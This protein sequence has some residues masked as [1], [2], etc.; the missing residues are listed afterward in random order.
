MTVSDRSAAEML[1]TPVQFL[2]GVGPARAEL[3]ERLGLHALRDVLFFFPR[4]YQD[5]SDE[6]EADQLEEG[7]LQSVRGTVDDVD[8]RSTSA[9]RSILGVSIRGKAGYVRAIWFNQ[10]FMR[11]RFALGQRVLIAGKPK[12]EGLVWQFV[13]P[14]VETLDDEEEEP[15]TRMLPVYPLTEGLQQWQIRKIVRGAIDAYASLLDE[16]FP[17]EYLRAH[18][19]WPLSQALP[20]VH[21]PDDLASLDRARR[22]LVYQELFILQL[23]LAVRRQQQLRPVEAP[24]LVATAKIDARIRRLFPFELTAG[25][26]Q[27]IAEISADM[28]AVA[29]MNRLLQGDV[30]SGKTVVAAYA[31]LLAVAH[32]YQAVLMA[33]TE[34]LARQHAQTLDRMLAAS[35]V[36]R[37]QLTGGLASA[38]RAE[39]LRRIAA[40]EL[41]VLVG[42]HAVIQDDVSFARLGLVVIDEQHKF[43]VR[44]RAILKQAGPDPHYLVM[45]ATPI[46][47]SV[48]MAMFGDL[49]ISTLRDSPPGRQKVNT[50]LANETK[51]A[52]WW[53]F[54]RKKLREG[55]QG[56]VIAPL[57]EE[58]DA[59][60]AASVDAM[61]E[62]LANGELEAF[63]LAVIHGR[64][65]PA[66][67]DAAMDRFRNGDI[68]VLVSTSVVEVGV[69]VPN[70]T[71][72]TIESGHRFG[73]A[74]LHQLRGRVSRGKFPGFCCVFGEP[75]TEESQERLKAFVASTDGFALAETDFLLRGPGDLFGTRQHGLPP[76]RIAD[77]A[78]RPGDSRR[79]PPRRPAPR[80][81]RSRT[82][83]RRARQA[84]ADDAGPLRKGPRTRRRGVTEF[85]PLPLGEG[86]GA[87]GQWRNSRNRKAAELSFRNDIG[88]EIVMSSE[89]R[90]LCASP[91][92]SAYAA[93]R[94]AV[95]ASGR[96]AAWTVATIAAVLVLASAGG[97]YLRQQQATTGGE[98]LRLI[99]TGPS[100]LHAG[101]AAD[102]AI[103]TMATDGRPLAAEIESVISDPDGKRLWRC[104][105]PVDDHGR[106]SIA[107]PAD[108]SFP[109]RV[110]LKVIA[111]HGDSRPEM[112]RPLNVA[113]APYITQLELDK[114]L[115]RPG[116]TIFYRWLTLSRLGFEPAPIALVHFEIRDS[117]GEAVPH[118]SADGRARR[119]IASGDFAIPAD[120]PPGRYTLVCKVAGTLRVPSPA[121]P[122][123]ADPPRNEQLLHFFIRP[124]QL[125]PY[126]KKPNS[127]RDSNPPSEPP[128]VQPGKVGVAFYPEGVA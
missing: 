26:E 126:N 81:G 73:L 102:Y 32:G 41:D 30:G 48:T 78:A 31:M 25:Q 72:M 76:L 23:A 113:S 47:R 96:A 74:Q 39:L 2:K 3:L 75:Q 9:G 121:R 51:R 125:A 24:P 123:A 103:S 44:Q 34:V 1:A 92:A 18:D 28:A 108:L 105:E 99:V 66:E 90:E 128:P 63:R 106:L 110:R 7:R 27:A 40:G 52:R 13:H 95:R 71:L 57:V 19:L 4:D 91:S 109:P 59:A 127:A 68:Q 36:R 98:P 87:R 17:D 58:S 54:F 83:G 5:F 82:V 79:G 80:H 50:Y 20:Q 12:Y 64:M 62:S 120:Q 122:S 69:D 43:G 46:P 45:T 21:F 60:D 104:N 117:Q 42:T 10:P 118:S 56:F 33:P 29:P 11:E 38:E 116:E 101:V 61:Y 65:T 94:A 37:G 8:L 22:R 107:I 49:D 89:P 77:L 115:Y 88:Q 85:S 16:V 15:A 6:R 35:H 93:S 114:P 86:Q 70:A 55:R 97:Y 112:D 124:Y 14:R 119:G 111:R 67:K 53:D 84:A 100:V